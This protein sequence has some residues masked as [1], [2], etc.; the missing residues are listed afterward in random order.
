ME[1]QL[2]QIYLFVCQSYDTCSQ[3]CFQRLSNN[4]KPDFTDQELITIWFFALPTT[5]SVVQAM[6]FERRRRLLSRICQ[7]FKGDCEQSAKA[8]SIASRAPSQTFN[9]PEMFTD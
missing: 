1:N 9:P 4:A 3:S 6:R 8:R 7:H 5:W 2:I